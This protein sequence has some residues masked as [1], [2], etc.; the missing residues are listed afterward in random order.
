M[1]IVQNG[2]KSRILIEKMLKKPIKYWIFD[3][4]MTKNIIIKKK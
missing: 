1:L 3:V 2:S 4:K